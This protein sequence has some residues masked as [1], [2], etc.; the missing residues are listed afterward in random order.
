MVCR[1][2]RL[3]IPLAPLAK[4]P[5]SQ[6]TFT[7]TYARTITVQHGTVHITS[8]FAECLE[9]NFP[10]EMDS[11]Y[12]V[13]RRCFRRAELC[14]AFLSFFQPPS[15]SFRQTHGEIWTALAAQGAWGFRMSNP[16]FILFLAFF[17]QNYC[18][19][20]TNSLLWQSG[21]NKK[22]LW[23]IGDLSSA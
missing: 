23:R 9:F 2:S 16:C 13:D 10:P 5:I 21:K 3:S 12:S 14:S 22:D 1:Q 8:L 15:P 19:A 20:Q 4:V 18:V 7:F 6:S 11:R 17:C